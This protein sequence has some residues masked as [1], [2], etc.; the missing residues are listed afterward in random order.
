MPRLATSTPWS[1]LIDDETA[2]MMIEPIQ[3]E[4]GVRIPPDG[5]LAGLR[6]LCDEHEL[7]LIFDEVQT[8]CGRTGEWFAYQAFRRH[9][10][11][12]DA[13]EGD[14]R[15]LARRSDADHGRNRQEPAAGD[16]RL[17][18]WRQSDRR[19]RR[20]GLYRDGR[21]REPAGARPKR[22]GEIFQQRLSSSNK[23]AIWSAMSACAA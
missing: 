4:G 5:F 13:V 9:A 3:G 23:S 21:S 20:L 18:V 19:P 14:L 10:R 12:D 22:L 11:C 1:R 17:H 8:G 2:A 15:R 6:K 16:A 7:L